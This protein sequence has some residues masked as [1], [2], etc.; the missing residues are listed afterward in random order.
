MKLYSYEGP[1]MVFET[2]VA[3]NWRGVTYATSEARARSNL[4]YQAKKFLGKLP[5]S[6]VTL[7]GR[8]QLVG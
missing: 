4:T 3:S 8:I 6:R 5:S 2:C 1:I 7:P